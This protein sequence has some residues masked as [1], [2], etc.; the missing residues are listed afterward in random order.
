MNVFGL[1]SGLNLLMLLISSVSKHLRILSIL[2]IKDDIAISSYLCCVKQVG[3][4]VRALFFLIF[5]TSV[6]REEIEKQKAHERYMR[7]QEQGK[8]EQ[9]RKDLGNW[10]LSMHY[11]SFQTVH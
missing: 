6:C 7:L 8:T 5:I 9:A 2:C 11:F 10:I 4:Q 1:Y 3:F